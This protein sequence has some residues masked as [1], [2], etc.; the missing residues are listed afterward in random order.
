MLPA[1]AFTV[2]MQYIR[3]FILHKQHTD[4]LHSVKSA[5]C[6]DRDATLPYLGALFLEIFAHLQVI[7]GWQQPQVQTFSF[8]P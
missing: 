7:F 5:Y 3:S 1:L 6:L 2:H 8:L 4:L